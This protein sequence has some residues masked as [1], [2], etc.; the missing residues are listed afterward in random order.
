MS[1]RPGPGRGRAHAARGP[2][3]QS[4]RSAQHVAREHPARYGEAP[5]PI[6]RSTQYEY[7]TW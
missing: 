4:R 2:A 1:W 5:S 7:E 6:W 3:R